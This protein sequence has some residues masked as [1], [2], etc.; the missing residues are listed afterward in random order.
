LILPKVLKLQFQLI[1]LRDMAADGLSIISVSKFRQPG[2]SLIQMLIEETYFQRT[3]K[4]STCLNN[5][6]DL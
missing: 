4:M 5:H 3:K 1:A 2:E 6:P